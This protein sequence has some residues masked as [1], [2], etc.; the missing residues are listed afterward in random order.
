MRS[1]WRKLD[2]FLKEKQSKLAY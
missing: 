1:F 2:I